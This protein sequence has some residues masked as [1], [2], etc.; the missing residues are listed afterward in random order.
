MDATAV[1][2]SDWQPMETAPRD[3]SL[4]LLLYRGQIEVGR[5]NPDA[6]NWA[7][8]TNGDWEAVDEEDVTKWR[9]LPRQ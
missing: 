2:M 1:T 7:E 8:S 5:W 9:P 3:G 4:I 6:V